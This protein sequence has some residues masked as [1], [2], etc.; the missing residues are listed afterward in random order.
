[1][2]IKK[3]LSTKILITDDFAK[4]VDNLKR[5]KDFTFEQ[6]GIYCNVSHQMIYRIIKRR[7]KNCN[8]YKIDKI[9]IAMGS[10][11]IYYLNIGELKL[12]KRRWS[13]L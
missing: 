13:K 12:P 4:R 10:P 7:T 1:M 8:L 11:H 5:S 9:C 2:R 6:M 3:R